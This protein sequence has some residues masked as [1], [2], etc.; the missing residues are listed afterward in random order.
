MINKATKLLAIMALGLAVISA[1]QGM[2]VHRLMN[3]KATA[4]NNVTESVN[5][6]KSN[7]LALGDS[8]KRWNKDYRTQDS[9]PDLMTLIAIVRLGDY[10]LSTDTDRIILNK[11]EPITQ[12]GASI[13]LT[14]V[15]LATT[16]NGSALEV[17]APSY[18]AL[19]RGVKQLAHRPDIYADAIAIKGDKSTPVANLG[20]F[21][22]LLSN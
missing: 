19:F 1:T 7:Y 5:R 6:W 10:G 12:N 2:K 9:V 20:E 18:K 3:E 14:K 13:G 4:Q 8:I 17:K 11:I 15:C 22:V 16:S 21:C